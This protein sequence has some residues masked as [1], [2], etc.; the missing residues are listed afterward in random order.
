MALGN[1][2]TQRGGI[3]SK[4]EKE[5]MAA[6]ANAVTKRLGRG[7]PDP[8]IKAGHAYYQLLNDMN[9]GGSA[10]FKRGLQFDFPRLNQVIQAID[11]MFGGWHKK[12]FF[13]FLELRVAYGVK[14]EMA[15]LCKVA[16]IGKVRAE[17]LWKAGLRNFQ[18]IANNPALVSS[19]LKMKPDKVQEIVDSAAFMGL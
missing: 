14:P 4:S 9:T 10:G 18:Q 8:V 3:C 6:Y 19:V 17:K 5:E 16:N 7:I 12:Q 11:T 13:K 15:H 2:D 1:V